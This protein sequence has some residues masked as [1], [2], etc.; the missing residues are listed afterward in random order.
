MSGLKK[1]IEGL[2]KAI[3]F[4]G[5]MKTVIPAPLK[6][7]RYE[8]IKGKPQLEI[9]AEGSPIVL[10][11][12]EEIHEDQELVLLD[13]IERDCVLCLMEY[14][15]YL[16]TF[17]GE[18][19]DNPEF[20]QKCNDLYLRTLDDRPVKKETL[21]ELCP[22]FYVYELLSRESRLP[23]EELYKNLGLK[24][25]EKAKLLKLEQEQE[26]SL[27]VSTRPEGSPYK[28]TPPKGPSPKEH[29]FRVG[30]FL[31]WDPEDPAVREIYKNP[32]YSP[33]EVHRRVAY[34]WNQVQVTYLES[35]ETIER[36][37]EKLGSVG[38][39]FSYI[40]LKGEA[41][42][43]DEQKIMDG[44]EYIK[45][46]M[47]EQYE[48]LQSVYDFHTKNV[49]LPFPMPQ[50]LQD[51]FLASMKDMIENKMFD[52]LPRALG[53]PDNSEK[54]IKEMQIR[55]QK[56]MDAMIIDEK[57]RKKAVKLMEDKGDHALVRRDLTQKDNELIRKM[58]LLSDTIKIVKPAE[59][60][61]DFGTPFNP[62]ELRFKDNETVVLATNKEELH[63]ENLVKILYLNNSNPEEFDVE[64][65]AQE[66]NI[67]TQR[68]RNIFFNYS[69]LIYEE[70]KVVGKLSF[71]DI[72]RKK[73]TIFD[74]YQE[75]VKRE[76]HAGDK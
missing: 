74:A 19:V 42:S 66:L 58:N 47:L 14:Y 29:K 64:F 70:G 8:D 52:D 71:I 63:V 12:M 49:V 51:M 50:W 34:I 73:T 41:C 38:A 39:V 23:L 27:I 11:R 45:R 15:E 62:E 3:K 56:A 1:M 46:L 32:H 33:Y 2:S 59:P 21:L 44:I 60:I 7:R 75:T 36:L 37:E 53:I 67:S 68:L 20:I 35:A 48:F 76:F 43:P 4:S 18:F 16:D 6:V 26:K 22:E 55:E 25:E 24:P 13:D 65:W 57:D 40:K 61:P 10:P 69:Y 9:Q 72:P 31:I 54:M 17:T 30:T 5:K 28:L